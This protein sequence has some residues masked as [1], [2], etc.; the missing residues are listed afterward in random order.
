MDFSKICFV[1]KSEQKRR[2]AK[3][4]VVRRPKAPDYGAEFGRRL[5]KVRAEAGLTQETLAELADIS[6]D[7]VK[8]L[9]GGHY[10]P[11][12]AVVDSIRCALNLS[13]TR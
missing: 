10:V 7:Y 13:W 2:P 9:E 1:S 4:K 6:T 5:K 11:T 8:R 3:R 12:I